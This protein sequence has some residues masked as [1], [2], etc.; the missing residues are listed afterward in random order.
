MEGYRELLEKYKLPLSLSLIGLVLIIGGIFSSGIAKNSAKQ[1]PRESIVST[2]S[3]IVTV[4]VSG[5]VVTSGVY[6]L[7]KGAIIEEAILKAGGFSDQANTEF[8]SKYLNL[9]QKISDGSKIYV[10]FIGEKD[11]DFAVSKGVAGVSNQPINLNT[12][13]QAELETLSGIGPVT[14]S[15]IIAGRPY[16]KLEELIEKKVVSKSVFEKIKDQLV[17]Y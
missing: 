10:P 9:A 8:I 14:A 11:T 6:Q 2:N 4:D 1:F 5:A 12:A 15:K 17:V 16:R 3:D 7:K 13:S